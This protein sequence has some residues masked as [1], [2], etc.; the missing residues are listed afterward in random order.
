[1]E[2]NHYSELKDNEILQGRIQTLQLIDPYVGKYYSLDWVRK[3]VLHQSEEEIKQI[4]KE[5]A[6]NPVP[7]VDET[8]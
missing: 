4:D 1:M 6:E 2:D 8:Q 5:N 7:T 3:N